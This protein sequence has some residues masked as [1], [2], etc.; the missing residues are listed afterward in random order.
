MADKAKKSKDKPVPTTCICG[1]APIDVKAMGLG[2]CYFCKECSTRGSWQ[3]S[4]DMAIKNWNT[5]VQQ[6]RHSRRT[7]G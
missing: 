1:A 3:K 4:R 5:E 6:V 7:K 2:I